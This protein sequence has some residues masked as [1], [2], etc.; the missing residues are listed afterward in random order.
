MARLQD[1]AL[2]SS[3]A[4]NFCAI[5]YL[6]KD[7]GGLELSSEED[8]TLCLDFSDSICLCMAIT[9][10]GGVPFGTILC[11]CVLTWP[12]VPVRKVVSTLYLCRKS[13]SFSLTISLRLNQSYSFL[14]TSQKKNCLVCLLFSHCY[15]R[16]KDFSLSS[17][18]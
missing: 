4:Q 16:S 18:F 1:L 11:V 14:V 6:A 2:L 17:T 13:S 5:M 3:L 12:V 7:M 15:F 10:L 9:T 8:C